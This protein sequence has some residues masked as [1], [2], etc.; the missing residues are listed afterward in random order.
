MEGKLFGTTTLA[1]DDV[2]TK[3]RLRNSAVL[4]AT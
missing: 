4:D 3:L 2:T 1:R